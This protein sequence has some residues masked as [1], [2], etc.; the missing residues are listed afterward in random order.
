MADLRDFL[1]A[2]VLRQLADDGYGIVRR[3]DWVWDEP[4]DLDWWHCRRCGCTKSDE[5]L[6]QSCEPAAGYTPD[7]TPALQGDDMSQADN[8]VLSGL[9]ERLAALAARVAALEERAAGKELH[10]EL[11]GA[12]PDHAAD[13]AE[14]AAMAPRV[15]RR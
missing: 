5:T 10:G 12:A 7:T 6:E 4:R 14:R 9:E 2:S 8:A 15:P 11:Y 13:R 3:H 1:P